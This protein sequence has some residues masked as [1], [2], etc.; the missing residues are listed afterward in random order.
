MAASRVGADTRINSILRTIEES[1]SVK[2]S[3]QGRYERMA[4]ATVPY[5]FLIAGVVYAL[6]RNLARAG[7]VLLVDY[8]CAIRLATPLAIFTAMREAADRGVLIKGGKY[9]EAIAEADTVVFDKTGTLTR[10]KPVLVGVVP[11]GGRRRANCCRDSASS[12]NS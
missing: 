9:M 2:A 1:E 8:S 3:I 5:N 7:S 12:G 10:A 11:F 6:T 4:D